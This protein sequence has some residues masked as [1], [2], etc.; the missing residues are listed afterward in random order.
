M[1]GSTIFMDKPIKRIFI[2]SIPPKFG[3]V[4][5]GNGPEI[6][7]TGRVDFEV[8]GRVL[9]C[10]LIVEHFITKYLEAHTPAIVDWDGS[11]LS[12]YQKL[13]LASGKDSLLRK[14]KLIP[15]IKALNQIRNQLSHNLEA[16]ISESDVSPIIEATN[17]LSRDKI[18]EITDMTP[19]AVIE[20][21]TLMLS[22]YMTG[23]H[24]GRTQKDEEP[25]QESV[26]DM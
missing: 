5:A 25:E 2:E 1:F 6:L 17:T 10:H 9:S 8:I 20:F 11:R 24:T 26:R 19:V 15:A 7:K 16:T 21:F 4:R 13:T 22:S 3:D 14:N 18:K 23:Y 12:F